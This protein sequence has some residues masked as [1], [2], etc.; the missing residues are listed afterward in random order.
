[1][2]EVIFL[3]VLALIWIVFAVVSDLRKR[4][5]PNWLC[6]SLIVFALGFRFFYS[7]FQGENFS[8][9]YHGL[10]GFGIF[11]VL[12]NLL[13]YGRMFAGGDAKLMIAFGAVLPFSNIF[14]ENLIIF[15][16]F[17]LLFLVVGAVYGLVWS[18]LLSLRNFKN[19]KKEFYKQLIKNK[20]MFKLIMFL[21]LVFMIAGF[22]EGSL[23]YFGILIFLFVYLYTYAKAVDEACM[24]KKI[25]SNKLTEGDWLYEDVKIGKKTIKANWDG[26]TKEQIK[27]IKGK[28]KSVLIRQGIPFGP[29][30]LIAFLILFYF[31]Q[32]GLWNSFW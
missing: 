11:L 32:S 3:F 21:G 10:I 26:L 6:F 1:M 19:F 20:T 15:I 22:F 23:F 24:I 29:V 31:W 5:I 8:F 7:F 14:S 4:E 12:G 18:L 27:M 25:S 17:F 13:Y 16:L 2:I 28:H 9:F 30:F